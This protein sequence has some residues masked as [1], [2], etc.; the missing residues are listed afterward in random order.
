MPTSD[1]ARRGDRRLLASFV[2][3]AIG[4]TFVFLSSLHG[5]LGRRPPELSGPSAIPR[6]HMAMDCGAAALFIISHLNGG[7]QSLA[8]LRDLTSTSELGT[9]MLN[10]KEA[11]TSIG[12]G[13]HGNRG[14]FN[15]LVSYVRK[16]RRYAVLHFRMG[17]FMA[18]VGASGD[19]SRVR[20]VDPSIGIQ[21]FGPEDLQSLKWSGVMLVLEA[22]EESI[23]EQP[24]FAKKSN[25]V[26]I[27]IPAIAAGFEG[28]N[29]A[30]AVTRTSRSSIARYSNSTDESRVKSDGSMRLSA[31]TSTVNLGA[32]PIS[33]TH[34]FHVTITNKPHH[35][36]LVGRV[37]PNC[38]CTNVTLSRHHIPAGKTA[39]L[40]GE[41]HADREPARFR[42]EIEVYLASS[43][44][45]DV[46]VAII[47]ECVRTINTTQDTVSVNPDP[48]AD[49]SDRVTVG[50]LNN[51][52]FP[53]ELS[54]EPSV[55]GDL[56][57]SL[58]KTHLEPGTTSEV[59]LTALPNLLT[60]SAEVVRIFTTHPFEK[61]VQIQVF[62]QPIG[63]LRVQPAAVRFG[64]LSAEQFANLRPVAI[65]IT[66]PILGA[67]TLAEI[68]TP[69]VLSLSYSDQT[70]AKRVLTFVTVS[71]HIMSSIRGD[72]VLGFDSNRSAKR[73]T[74]R[75]PVSGIVRDA[76]ADVGSLLLQSSD[77]NG[78]TQ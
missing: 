61:V 66:G 4:S 44:E 19:Y 74:T 1:P 2:M 48:L 70:E 17:H 28:K 13:A 55:T 57:M 63:A 78:E 12:F 9:N 54:I 73:F 67:V 3:G 49:R 34:N 26:G 65:T 27:V 20:V 39:D 68:E 6:G 40:T 71:S 21:D 29:K 41:F 56:K 64:V 5:I 62:V 8:A 53:I 46:T 24:G 69:P 22:P 14:D 30:D 23:K 47:G 31:S 51:S 42:K 72:I 60:R 58:S 25:P 50:V 76:S 36:V 38:G 59:R 10:L 37:S 35:D 16:P 52:T 11:A 75:I 18:V 33:T 77:P 45:P 32:I 15:D 43:T 7:T